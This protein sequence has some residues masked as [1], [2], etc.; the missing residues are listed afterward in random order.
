V[1]VATLRIKSTS[2]S[3]QISEHELRAS[4]VRA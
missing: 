1:K 4:I 2:A 3:W